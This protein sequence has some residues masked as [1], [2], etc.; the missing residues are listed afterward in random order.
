MDRQQQMEER[1]WDYIDGLSSTAERSVIG[2][3]IADHREWQIKYHELLEVH[4][5]I[6]GS[7]LEAP[8]LR[9]TKNVMED[10]A[11]FQ[12]APATN[13]YINKYI[14]RGIGAFFLLMIVG[15]MVYFLGQMHW[16]GAPSSI[17]PASGL[18]TK[19]T[20]NVDKLDWSRLLGSTPT[21][22]FLLV[23]TVLGLVLLDMYLTRKKKEL[24][25][26][27]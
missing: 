13:S 11:R 8:S 23:N 10:I 25:K 5:A 19:Y 12:V 18:L 15:F 6:H 16:T 24:Q 4:K 2:Q 1:L 21:T 27:L 7:E 22:I 26:N 3:L 17:S 20:A 9:F 14:I